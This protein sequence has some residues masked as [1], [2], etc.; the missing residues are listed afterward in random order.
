[1]ANPCLRILLVEDHEPTR[2][3]LA[4]LLKRRQHLVTAAGTVA[5]ALAAAENNTFDLV[6][7][8]IGLPDGTGNDLMRELRSRYKLR[9][10]ALTGYGMSEDIARTQAAGFMTHLTKPISV[11]LLDQALLAAHDRLM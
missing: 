5:E 7:S 1:L 2:V 3:A 10:I 9:G 4:Q 11:Q 8:D 6:M